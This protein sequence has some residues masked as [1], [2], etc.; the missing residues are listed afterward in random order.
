MAT[1]ELRSATARLRNALRVPDT[2]HGRI[3]DPLQDVNRECA[4]V[5]VEHNLSALWHGSIPKHAT[6]ASPTVVL[7]DASHATAVEEHIMERTSRAAE[8][9]RVGEL[10]RHPETRRL[11]G[12][13]SVSMR[14][15]VIEDRTTA[16]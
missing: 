11:S 7:V 16:T 13:I 14:C 9:S 2:Q 6:H 8:H 1:P 12:N 5:D 4:H 10:E 15:H 3:A